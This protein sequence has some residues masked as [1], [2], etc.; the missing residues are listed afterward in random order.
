ML[1]VDNTFI[2]NFD[3]QSTMVKNNSNSCISECGIIYVNPFLKNGDGEKYKECL[4]N[5]KNVLPSCQNYCNDSSNENTI[6]CN[7]NN[8]NNDD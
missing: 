4:K 6:Y 5:C 1:L 2:D 7:K 8:G 3:N